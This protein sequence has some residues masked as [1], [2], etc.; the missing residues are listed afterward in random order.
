[1]ATL[2]GSAWDGLRLAACAEDAHAFKKV[3]AIAVTV[4]AHRAIHPDIGALSP[5][6]VY[7]RWLSW[8]KSAL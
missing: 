6:R 5:R 4:A 7:R 8:R 2:S 3:S 1:M